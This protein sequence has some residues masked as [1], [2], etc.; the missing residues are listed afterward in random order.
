MGSFLS[1][2]VCTRVWWVALRYW[3][4]M[5]YH[6][7]L[8]IWYVKVPDHHHHHCVNNWEILFVQNCWA[9]H[10]FC[11]AKLTC[12]DTILLSQTDMFSHHL[13]EPN[14]YVLTFLHSILICRLT[15]WAPLLKLLFFNRRKSGTWWMT[16][17]VKGR[18]PLAYWGTTLT[19]PIH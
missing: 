3:K 12:F 9:Q 14:W 10:P 13:A 11:W 19:S 7:F 5:G 18:S 17:K 6:N 16:F 2:G 15:C 4:N 1:V 8:W